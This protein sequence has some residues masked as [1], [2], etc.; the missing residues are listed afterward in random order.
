VQCFPVSRSKTQLFHIPTRGGGGGPAPAHPWADRRR[1]DDHA[2]SVPVQKNLRFECGA[3]RRRQIRSHVGHRPRR[4]RLPHFGVADT[5]A[6]RRR[7]RAGPCAARHFNMTVARC[8][9]DEP[10]AAQRFAAAHTASRRR[11]CAIT[12]GSGGQRDTGGP[13]HREP[14][15][16]DSGA[17]PQSTREKRERSCRDA[18][19]HE[20][21]H[22]SFHLLPFVKELT[23]A[24]A[25]FRGY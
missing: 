15:H 17:Q 19:A 11:A 7:W 4:E 13:L 14:H 10:Q 22:R 6:R 8:L 2:F 23:K 5:H 3:H 16:D 21:Q 25:W 20:K 24:T 12:A 1:R 18:A 9:F